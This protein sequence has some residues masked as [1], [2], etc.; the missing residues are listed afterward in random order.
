V[1]DDIT[2][3]SKDWE[4][5]ISPAKASSILKRPADLFEAS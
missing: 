1:A 2:A 4:F 5:K 3:R